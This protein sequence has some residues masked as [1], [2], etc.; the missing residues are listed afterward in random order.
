MVK[1]L[2]YC[3]V[4]VL[5]III[6][7]NH[8]TAQTG[9]IKGIVKGNES[10][11]PL[12]TV[13]IAGK[14]MLTNEKGEFH[15]ALNPGNYTLIIT[16]TGY[17][18]MEVI[19]KVDSGKTYMH[20]FFLIPAFLLGEGVMISSRSMIHRSNLTIPVPVNIYSSRNLIGTGQPS[21]TQML[22]FMA[23]SLNASRQLVNESITLRGLDPDQVLIL[24]NGKR[25]PNLAYVNHGSVRGM[26]GRGAVANDLNSIPF[27]AI[28]KIEILSDGAAAQYGS[29]A[30]TGVINIILKETA[31]KTW[32]QIL[33][34]EFYKGDGQS[35]KMGLNHGI[36][37]NKKGFLNFSADFL[38]RIPTYRGGE[39]TGTVYVLNPQ[40]D[41]VIIQSRNFDRK[42]VSNAGSSKYNSHGLLINGGYPFKKRTEIF[43]TVVF[44][45]RRTVFLS[46]RILPKFD[47][48]VNNAIFPDGFQAMPNHKI[49]NMHFVTGLK[50]ATKNS[51]LWEYSTTLGNNNDRYK[52][53]NTNN[54]SQFF[55]LGKNAPTSFYTGTLIYSQLIHSFQ[56]SRD[57]SVNPKWFF[58][59]A[60]GAEWR[61][62]N[63]EI[64]QGEQASWKNYDPSGRKQG[65][66]LNGLVF[67]PSNAVNENRNVIGTYID[68]EIEYKNRLLFDIAT[69]YEHYSDFGSNLAGKIAMRY[70]LFKNC[71]LRSSVSNGFRAPSLQQRFYS[72]TNN[73]FINVNGIITP[74]T[75]GIFRNNSA[76]ASAFGIPSLNAEKSI[77]VSGGMTASFLN[78]FS[79]TADIY[80]I[81]IRNRIVLSGVFDTTNAEARAILRTLPG[82]D[83]VQFFVNAINTRTLGLDVVL[84]G[85]WQTK[86]NS[87]L[88]SLAANFNK[89]LLFGNIKTAAR[90][91]ADS[92]N[93]NT[94]FSREERVRLEDGQPSDKIILTLNYKMGKFGFLLRN[95]RFGKTA[96]V[97]L[98]NNTNRDE[99][100][101]PKI[102]TDCSISY[103]PLPW[104]SITAG[105]NNIS[106]IYPDRIRNPLNTGEGMFIYGQEAT[107]FGFNGG[108]FY[109][110]LSFNF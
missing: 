55:T 100:F 92:Q 27:S 59:L 71:L 64:K 3:L 50:G 87:L 40:L 95:T 17:E 69:R 89:T 63:F 34:G 38:H 110:N 82:I 20:E 13:S 74:V 12:A 46:S 31:G 109:V 37:I 7:L 44:N 52:V 48:R 29:D 8:C 57:L 90:L 24:I 66:A 104:F 76:E 99:F 84:N 49:K 35:F 72:F 45:T 25:Y 96:I 54:P 36:T 26:L 33:S 101:S 5:H 62:E 91:Q 22:Q 85:T 73:T 51:W 14:T 98:A 4:S 70:K 10:S 81:Q 19:L 67:H 41:E 65:G 108:Y 83:Q 11:L 106:N 1:H 18:R 53:K 60:A 30:I 86:K 94:L 58:H 88:I 77:N 9:V 75:R 42:K 32:A 6:A 16:H 78:H 15:I 97:F 102:L 93:S 107:P 23:P 43:W 47:A 2:L 80:W 28:E 61:F 79:M 21:L 68:I 39:Y 56:L 105:A 103:T